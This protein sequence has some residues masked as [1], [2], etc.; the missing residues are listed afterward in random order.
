MT[1]F[2]IT[3]LENEDQFT[4]PNR[5]PTIDDL[6]ESITVIAGTTTTEIVGYPIDLEMDEFV[7]TKWETN[8]TESA[9]WV[10]VNGVSDGQA[11]DLLA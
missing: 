6:R 2:L 9:E 1:P 11:A 10:S 7:L 3:V 5:A 4:V 8:T